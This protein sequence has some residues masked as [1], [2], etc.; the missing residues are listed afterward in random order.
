LQAQSSSQET[1]QEAGF[2]DSAH[3]G[4][5]C[6]RMIGLAPASLLRETVTAGGAG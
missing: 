1:A 5:T 6:R 2:A 4:R 3:L